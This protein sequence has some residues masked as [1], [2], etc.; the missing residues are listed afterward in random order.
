MDLLEDPETLMSAVD[1]GIYGY[2]LR[3][4]SPAEWTDVV[5]R[6][7]RG[8][9]AL[10]RFHFGAGTTPALPAPERRLLSLLAVGLTSRQ[11]AERLG[12]PH[13]EVPRGSSLC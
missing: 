1:L 3:D 2:L 4:A 5:Q 8:E 9:L 11:I 10:G 12:L 6:V 13:E 7:A